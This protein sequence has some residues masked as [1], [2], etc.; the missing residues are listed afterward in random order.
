MGFSISVKQRKQCPH[1]LEYVPYAPEETYYCQ[2]SFFK[3][4]SDN[5]YK[6]IQTILGIV[7][8]DGE[9]WSQFDGEGEEALRIMQKIESVIEP[10]EYRKIMK[11]LDKP[12]V[13]MYASW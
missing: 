10:N 9:W 5:P 6:E 3:P 2:K 7:E 11:A 4:T 8:K 13:Y 1:C 12:G